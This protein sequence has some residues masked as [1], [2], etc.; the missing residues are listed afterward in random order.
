MPNSAGAFPL[1]RRV[2]S[3]AA[4]LGELEALLDQAQSPLSDLPVDASAEDV[5]VMKDLEQVRAAEHARCRACTP[6][7]S[8]HTF[9][10]HVQAIRQEAQSLSQRLLRATSLASGPLQRSE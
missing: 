9:Q 3:V 4:L 1:T 5:E 7:A 10:T 8:P 2:R 6:H